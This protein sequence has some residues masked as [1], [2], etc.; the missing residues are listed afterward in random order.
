MN[1]KRYMP[2]RESEPALPNEKYNGWTNWRTWNL[3]NWLTMNE[4]IY[5]KC[6]T[7]TPEQLKEHH[8]TPGALPPLYYSDEQDAPAGEINY[9]EIYDALNE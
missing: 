4:E 3:F 1:D 5:D 7:M 6:R 2:P 9:K 8:D